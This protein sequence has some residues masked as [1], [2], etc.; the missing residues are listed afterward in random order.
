MTRNN[1]S[2]SRSPKICLLLLATNMEGFR[3]D[4]QKSSGGGS[5]RL[6]KEILELISKR[7][8]LKKQIFKNKE[9]QLK[10]EFNQITKQIQLE[11]EKIRSEQWSR[12]LEIC[13]KNPTSSRP[14]WN[15]V[16][17]MRS[18]KSKTSYPPLVKDSQTYSSDAEKAYLF[19]NIL[20]NIF[21]NNENIERTHKLMVD[22]TVQKFLNKKEKLSLSRV[23]SY[24]TNQIIK[25]ITT[26]T[27]PGQDGIHN[28]MLKNLP[29]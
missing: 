19:S 26:N 25:E 18:K 9:T 1:S 6:P 14:Y 12:F 29:T 27:S 28:L 24:E 7:H 5:K 10:P 16:N 2:L 3:I 11:I 23:T 22:R 21:T 20:E 13:G 4:A 15:K 17:S 8:Q